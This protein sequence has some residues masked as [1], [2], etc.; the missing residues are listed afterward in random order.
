MQNLLETMRERNSKKRLET[1]KDEFK[2]ITVIGKGS[3]VK[4]VNANSIYKIGEKI[5]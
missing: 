1:L 5:K 4:K 3:P 2:N